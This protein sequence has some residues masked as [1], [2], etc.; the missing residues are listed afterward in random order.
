MAEYVPGKQRAGSIDKLSGMKADS[1]C[2][3]T[4][5][6]LIQFA[7]NLSSGKYKENSEQREKILKMLVNQLASPSENS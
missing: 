4:R 7:K 3:H 5:Q 1:F 6:E 2:Q